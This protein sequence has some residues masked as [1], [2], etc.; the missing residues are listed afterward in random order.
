MLEV[1]YIVSGE[2]A[3]K[4]RRG[5]VEHPNHMVQRSFASVLIHDIFLCDQGELSLRDRTAEVS[6]HL[7]SSSVNVS[8]SQ[9]KTSSTLLGD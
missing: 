5:K 3:S 1:L 9:I 6:T 4:K 8:M 2:K 7:S